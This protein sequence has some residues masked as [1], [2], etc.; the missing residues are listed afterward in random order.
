AAPGEV[1][2]TEAVE[3]FVERARA[4]RPAFALTDD[5]APAV[6]DVC[7]RLDGIPLALELAAAQ[8]RGLEPQQ[9][10]KLLGDG[11]P[12]LDALSTHSMPSRQRTLRS[13]QTRRRRAV[14]IT[15][16]H[17]QRPTL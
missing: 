10:A 14:I 6:L 15:T 17:A 3:F 8:I 7:R 12:L 5:N 4:T 11:M 9:L 13:T 16:I 2:H 1:A